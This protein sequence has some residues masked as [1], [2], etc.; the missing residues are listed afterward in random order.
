MGRSRGVGLAWGLVVKPFVFCVV[1]KLL[2]LGGVVILCGC[3]M[4]GCGWRC[5]CGCVGD[6]PSVWLCRRLGW[7]VCAEGIRCGRTV[8]VSRGVALELL[9][10]ALDII[11]IL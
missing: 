11:G 4:V 9:L 2:T 3:D 8:F 10:W 6:V 7:S 5:S 1:C